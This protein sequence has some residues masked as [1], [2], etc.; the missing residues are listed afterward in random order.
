MRPAY[1][2]RAGLI[3]WA[4]KLTDTLTI[5]HEE[6]RLLR[7]VYDEM[8]Q[9]PQGTVA[10]A[11]GRL[12]RA[13]VIA[14]DVEMAD[15]QVEVTI[16]IVR[17]QGEMARLEPDETFVRSGHNPRLRNYIDILHESEG[18]C[19]RFHKLVSTFGD[20]V[21]AVGD[22]VGAECEV[23]EERMLAE[24]MNYK[25]YS[26]DAGARLNSFLDYQVE[27]HYTSSDIE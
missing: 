21:A 22:A 8:E 24:L 5:L 9:P 20:F 18:R 11:L 7:E 2:N 6:F 13:T 1:K 15:T 23:L 25:H 19:R 26:H 14:V 27:I 17:L 3:A 10:H 12:P 16:D 4:N